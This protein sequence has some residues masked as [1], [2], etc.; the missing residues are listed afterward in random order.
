[1]VD[2]AYFV[3]AIPR[4]FILT[5]RCCCTCI[6]KSTPPSAYIGF[7]QHFAYMLPIVDHLGGFLSEPKML[8][9]A[10][11]V[12]SKKKSEKGYS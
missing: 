10:Y 2:S 8:N 12:K 1:M 11:S 5:L 7:F 6:V 4:A 9:S 3:K